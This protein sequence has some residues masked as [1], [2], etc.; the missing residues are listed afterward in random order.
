MHSFVFFYYSS[1]AS[2]FP[3]LGYWFSKQYLSHTQIGVLFSAGPVIGLFFQPIW[4]ML[5][6]RYGI[7]KFILTASIV[8]TPW[9]ALGYYF[10]HQHFYIYV[11]SAIMLAN[12]SSSIGPM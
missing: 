5:G 7:E 6:D 12:F 9:V 4:G 3:F 10:E 2:F 11:I 1:I 8:L